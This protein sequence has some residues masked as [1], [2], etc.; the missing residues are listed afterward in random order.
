MDFFSSEAMVK[1][2]FGNHTDLG[3]NFSSSVV[4]SNLDQLETWSSHPEMGKNNIHVVNT[5]KIYHAT[6]KLR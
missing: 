6:I 1:S 3:F 2:L 4:D 5:D